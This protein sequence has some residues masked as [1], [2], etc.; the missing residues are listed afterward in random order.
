[1]PRGIPF[2]EVSHGFLHS[3]THS[4]DKLKESLQVLYIHDNLCLHGT[5]LG[6]HFKHS[7][8]L[9]PRWDRQPSGHSTSRGVSSTCEVNLHWEHAWDMDQR[10]GELVKLWNRPWQ[11]HYNLKSLLTSLGSPQSKVNWTHSIEHKEVLLLALPTR[12]MQ[13]YCVQIHYRVQYLKGFLQAPR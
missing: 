7:C 6:V 1:M 13:G 12:A 4:L 3:T 11:D 2:L 5:H 8:G 9:F 10:W